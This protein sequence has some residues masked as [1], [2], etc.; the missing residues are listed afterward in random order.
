MQ[1]TETNDSCGFVAIVGKPNVGKSTLLNCLLAEKISITADKPQTTRHKILG[2]KTI[3]SKQ[4]IYVDTPGIH[5]YNKKQINQY[6]NKTAY[7]AV[8]DTDVIILVIEAL[9]WQNADELVVAKLKNINKPII[10]VV[11]KIDQ[12][13]DKMLLLPFL[14]MVAKKLDFTAIIPLSAKKNQQVN[15]LQE[16][17]FNLLPKNP[18]FYAAQQV[19]ASPLKFRLAEIVREKLTRNLGKELPYAIAVEIETIEETAKQ[20]VIYS[21]IWVERDSQKKIIIGKG[22]EKLKTIGTQARLDM[23]K[24]LHNKV[25]L[26]L[27][28]KVRSGWTDDKQALKNFGY[29]ELN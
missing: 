3:A 2:I 25:H 16:L 20:V 17:V 7:N 23:N 29:L 4:A 10:L 28:V 24:L 1:I 12:H 8:Y 27:W 22:G 19:T 13:K 11:N 6:M 21:I 14:E 9:I 5:R 15:E 26:K 18:H